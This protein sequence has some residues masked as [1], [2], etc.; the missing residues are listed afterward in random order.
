MFPSSVF[1]RYKFD[2]SK[3]LITKVDNIFGSDSFNKILAISPDK[4][5]A[6]FLNKDPENDTKKIFDADPS[7]PSKVYGELIYEPEYGLNGEW[8]FEDN[9]TFPNFSPDSKYII[10]TM[11]NEILVYSASNHK[12]I[13]KFPRSYLNG[14]SQYR[15]VSFSNGQK[16]IFAQL[17]NGN[18]AVL[19]LID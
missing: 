11:Y 15:Q 14:F 2:E 8:D 5:H 10:V 1:N 6:I 4:N 18:I 7:N 12:L 19:K 9:S 13:K 3:K 17:D 16:F